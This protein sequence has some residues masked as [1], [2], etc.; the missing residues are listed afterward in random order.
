MDVTQKWFLMKHDDSALFGPIGFE[1]L[2]QWAVEAYISPL[3]KVST[4]Q[5]TWV[6]APMIPELQMDYLIQIGP[7]RYYGPTTV[8]AIREF[9][10]RG[11]VTQDALIT[12]CKTGETRPLKEF[13]IF[14]PP[15]ANSEEIPGGTVSIRENLQGRIRELEEAL[16]QERQ[17]RTHAEE[18]RARL[19]ARL[20]ELAE[21]ATSRRQP[22]AI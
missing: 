1:L 22:E 10:E 20:L 3:D 6:K 18:Q 19:E 8:G 11:E 9:L 7:E 5:V 21:A 12:F 15:P 13:E 16:M 4:D 2:R 17:L 14:L